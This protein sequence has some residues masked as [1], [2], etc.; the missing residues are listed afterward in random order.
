MKFWNFKEKDETIELRI[1]GD[2]ISDN[3][4][5]IYEW[6]DI[7]A[8]SPNQFRSELKEH[9]GKDIVVWIDSY[10]G[11][12]FAGAGM[13]NALKNHNGK[14]T[15]KIDSKA[16]SAASVIAMAGDEILMSPV[17]ILMIHNPWTTASGDMKDLR[18]TADVL[19]SIKDSIINAYVNKTGRSN[20]SIAEMMDDESW[21]SANVAVK[22]G[23]ADG[24]L[25]DSE[26]ESQNVNNFGFN[27]MTV[28]NKANN[29]LDAAIQCIQKLDTNDKDEN[30]ND[31]D[32]K[33]N[34]SDKKIKDKEKLLLEI[35]LI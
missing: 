19:D 1:E 14:I 4:A 22:E 6:F 32:G 27:R 24:V 13:Y 5:W 25:Y 21:M 12:V 11:D 34:S 3:E 30:N 31:K 15:V 29:S 33:S 9:D 17:A 16:M 35:D 20:S 23:F 2:I 8:A 10:G 28:L 18:K 26:G 7:P